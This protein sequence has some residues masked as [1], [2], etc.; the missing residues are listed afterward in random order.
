MI[1]RVRVCLSTDHCACVMHYV[2]AAGILHTV[3]WGH[4]LSS[5]FSSA[6][7]NCELSSGTSRDAAP[8]FVQL[9]VVSVDVVT[10][11]PQSKECLTAER[12]WP[13]FALDVP[14]LMHH[15]SVT[16]TVGGG[17]LQTG[18]SR[19]WDFRGLA[20]RPSKLL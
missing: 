16:V 18:V 5:P 19:L 20:A 2:H 4:L 3:V 15:E 14:K 8:T 10:D 17:T 6:H 9:G 1:R 7:P 11:I 13:V 12:T